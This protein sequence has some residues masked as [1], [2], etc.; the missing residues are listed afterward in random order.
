MC[1]FHLGNVNKRIIR[2]KVENEWT[3]IIV[4][5]QD[6]SKSKEIKRF[7]LDEN[8]IIIIIIMQIGVNFTLL[9]RAVQFFH[10]NTHHLM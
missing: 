2:I 9:C 5:N 7:V 1:R 6:D 8:V 4:M 3:V 10:R